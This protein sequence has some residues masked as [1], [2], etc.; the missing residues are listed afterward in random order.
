M[1]RFVPWLVLIAVSGAVSKTWSVEPYV[2][3]FDRFGKANVESGLLL[4][5]ELGCLSCHRDESLSGE[6]AP[7]AAPNLSRVAQ[8]SD[9]YFLSK[10]IANPAAVHP[11]TTMPSLLGEKDAVSTATAIT[12]YLVSL[13]D[14]A[15][16]RDVPDT[17][18][19]ERGRELYGKVGCVACHV[20]T[21]HTPTTDEL[22]N[23]SRPFPDLTA[24]YSIDGLRTFLKDP[25]HTRPS[26]R[27]PNLRLSDREATEIANFLLR[28]T[29][30]NGP[31]SYQLFTGRKDNL[32]GPREQTLHQ[33]GLADGFQLPKRLPGSRFRIVFNGFVHIDSDGDYGFHW[34]SSGAIRFKVGD[35]QIVEQVRPPQRDRVHEGTKRI[36]LNRGWLPIELEYL[37]PRGVKNLNLQWD[38]PNI[39]RG[40]I[41]TSRLKHEYSSKEDSVRKWLFDEALAK[42]GGQL[43]V[44]TGCVSCHEKD[45]G[46]KM[47]PDGY[48]NAL[49]KLP[50]VG[51]CLGESQQGIPN[52]HL[53]DGQRD[54]IRAAITAIGQGKVTQRT[55]EERIAATMLRLNC[56]A[57]HQRGEIGGVTEMREPHFTCSEK[58]LGGEGNFPPTLSNV[59]DKLQIGWLSEVLDQGASVRPYMNTRMPKFGAANVRNLAKQLVDQDLQKSTIPDP[60]DSPDSA[61][62]VGRELA[63]RGKL[64]CISCHKFNRYDSAGLQAMDLVDTTRRLNRHWFHRYMLNPAALRPGTRMP[65]SWPGGETFYKDILDGDTQRQI[66][67]L[68]TYL[69]DGKLAI[70]PEGLVPRNKEL[71]VASKAVV[72]RNKLWEAGFR[73][74]A[75]GYSAHVNMAFDAQNK[76]LALLWKNRFL[77]VTSHWSRQSMGRVRPAGDDVIVLPSP[78]PFAKLDQPDRAWPTDENKKLNIKFGGYQLDELDRPTFLYQ[79]RDGDSTLQ[80]QDFS[81][82]MLDGDQFVLQRQLTLSG[83][84]KHGAIGWLIWN[85]S[86]VTEKAGVYQCGEKLKIRFQ[87]PENA[88]A[89]IAG[90]QSNELRILIDPTKATTNNHQ[91]KIG[92]RYQW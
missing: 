4:I 91:T 38:G 28:D 74:I 85:D 54:A 60:V 31:L 42:Q 39:Q 63:G 48:S 5:G 47:P 32:N 76:R 86:P 12:H 51:G 36:S 84:S 3:G 72:Y 41:A 67:S 55:G 16:R 77:N 24:K 49:A 18:A 17:V 45:S 43:F 83:E 53:S 90:D 82:G 23:S 52:F 69:S 26:G 2:V 87:L 14:K 89:F 22:A 56:Y 50:T 58:D 29:R 61:K 64:Q 75:V 70:N 10:Y 7:K 9:P 40:P 66:D 27:M 79:I 6:L 65:Q 81:D 57:C 11:G 15:F 20:S 19:I 88:K 8:R 71:V 37:E 44:S 46:Q 35:K 33:T 92:V 59:G 13:S 62:V 25:L 68:W 73:G 80:V 1:K 78:T 21:P 30:V 34:R